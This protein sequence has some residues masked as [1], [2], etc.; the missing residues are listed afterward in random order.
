[1]VGNFTEK[2]Y[3]ISRKTFAYTTPRKKVT[4]ALWHLTPNHY[5]LQACVASVSVACS[6]RSYSRARE[7]NSR[8]KKKRGETRGGKP[9]PLLN[10]WNRLVFPWELV[11]KKG[12]RAKIGMKGGSQGRKRNSVSS[13]FIC[14][15]PPSSIFWLTDYFLSRDGQIDG[16]VPGTTPRPR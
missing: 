10:A 11:G 6:R 16:R 8:R 15:P 12:T 3:T 9:P 2:K 1:M 7:K 14:S 13:M 5:F 4:L